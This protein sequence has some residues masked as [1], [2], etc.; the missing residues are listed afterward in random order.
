MR[1]R[2][3]TKESIPNTG[4]IP[5]QIISTTGFSG[6]TISPSVWKLV[7]DFSQIRYIHPTFI[8][9]K[10]KQNKNNIGIVSKIEGTMP[11]LL[12]ACHPLLKYQRH[13]IIAE[14]R[15]E[16]Q[17]N[18]IK[19]YAHAGHLFNRNETITIN[20]GIRRR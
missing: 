3:T 11:I 7:I 12:S 9:L 6:S 17:T 18:D 5:N 4:T 20:N 14:K 19:E 16:Y 8:D 2:N 13:N 15:H 10:N 1:K